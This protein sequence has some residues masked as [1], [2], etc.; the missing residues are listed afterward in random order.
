MYETI[1]AIAKKIGRKRPYVQW[2]DLASEAYLA[3]I[4]IGWAQGAT[5]NQEAIKEA[6]RTMNRLIKRER[7]HYA[8]TIP[9]EELDEHRNEILDNDYIM[10]NAK[11]L[12][13][14]PE[15]MVISLARD[16]LGATEIAD[17]TGMRRATV[18]AMMVEEGY[19]NEES[20]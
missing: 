12:S 13:G 4:E 11:C 20:D 3:V 18:R 5:T 9:L 6:V 2:E 1:V 19:G 7:S 14:D 8:K 10:R 15:G 16:G 17:I